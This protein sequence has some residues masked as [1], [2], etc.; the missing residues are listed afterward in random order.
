MML[1]EAHTF[2]TRKMGSSDAYNFQTLF[3]PGPEVKRVTSSSRK[4]VAIALKYLVPVTKK[5]PD[6]P[7]T[8]VTS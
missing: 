6:L 1:H 3:P 2:K 7:V 8:I 5:P 4:A